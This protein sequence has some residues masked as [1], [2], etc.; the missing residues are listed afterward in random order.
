[1]QP[2]LTIKNLWSYP[3]VFWSAG[4]MQICATMDQ[5][6]FIFAIFPH[7]CF[8]RQSIIMCGHGWLG[9]CQEQAGPEFS[10]LP[11]SASQ[12]QALKACTTRSFQF[13]FKYMFYAVLRLS[14]VG[15]VVPRWCGG[16]CHRPLCS[17]LCKGIKEHANKAPTAGGSDLNV[18]FLLSYHGID[19]S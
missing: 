17:F 5:L 1:M 13:H 14:G 8:L 10:D 11:A 3:L 7:L 18:K 15:G 2:R 16:F 12:V 6:L 9:T 4:I 19:L